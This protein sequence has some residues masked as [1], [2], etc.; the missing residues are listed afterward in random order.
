MMPVRCTSRRY[1]P[2]NVCAVSGLLIPLLKGKADRCFN[3]ADRTRPSGPALSYPG[4]KI[5]RPSTM[6]AF[7]RMTIQG[8]MPYERPSKR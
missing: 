1:Q 8:L 4:R 3:I 7:L 5:I 2:S 6:D